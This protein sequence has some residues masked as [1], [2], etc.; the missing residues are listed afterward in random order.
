V[1]GAVA[2]VDDAIARASAR[3]AA[4]GGDPAKRA[5]IAAEEKRI[6]ALHLDDFQYK[7]LARWRRT[8]AFQ[9]WQA[10]YKAGALAAFDFAAHAGHPTHV[11]DLPSRLLTYVDISLVGWQMRWLTPL[12]P[13]ICWMAPRRW[14]DGT[15]AG[16]AGHGDC[17][18]GRRLGAAVASVVDGARGRAALVGPRGDGGLGRGDI[19]GALVGERHCPGRRRGKGG[20]GGGG[21]GRC[22]GVVRAW[23]CALRRGR[24]WRRRCCCICP[25]SAQL[26]HRAVA[27]VLHSHWHVLYDRVP[28]VEVRLRVQRRPLRQG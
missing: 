17:G 22:C 15:G 26:K 6:A 18:Q 10:R 7:W 25:G 5:S 1:P 11:D 12:L 23:E 16:G 20:G 4:A 19:G 28:R 27:H 8:P 13:T 9:E 3:A 2:T 14:Q 21:G 24:E